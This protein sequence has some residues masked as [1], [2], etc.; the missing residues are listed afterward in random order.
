MKRSESELTESI[1]NSPFSE[2]TFFDDPRV[3]KIG[4]R[5]KSTLVRGEWHKSGV[6]GHGGPVEA[7][8]VLANP[9]CAGM[10]RGRIG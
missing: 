9:S 1:Y 10:P 7:A 3:C 8:S 5:H 6:G 2:I 4:Q